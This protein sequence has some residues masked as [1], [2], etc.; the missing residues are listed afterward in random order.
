M[1]LPT[2]ATSEH[3]IRAMETLL[4]DPNFDMLCSIVKKNDMELLKN[5]IITGKD[6]ASKE[7]LTTEQ[8]EE[9]R[10]KL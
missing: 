3:V 8:T 4:I 7:K 2:N 5:S 6:P 10:Y 9:M 1:Q